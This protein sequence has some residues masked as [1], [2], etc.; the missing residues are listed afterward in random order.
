MEEEKRRRD[1]SEGGTEYLIRNAPRRQELVS[2][3]RRADDQRAKDNQR[4][5]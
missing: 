3:R 1:A 5:E 2:E 4:T